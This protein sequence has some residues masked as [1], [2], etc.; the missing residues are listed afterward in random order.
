MRL[1]RFFPDLLW[2][3]SAREECAGWLE[4]FAAFHSLPPGREAAGGSICVAGRPHEFPMPVGP[5]WEETVCPWGHFA[6]N[7]GSS[8]LQVILPE[9]ENGSLVRRIPTFRA[10]LLALTF[11]LPEESLVLHGATLVLHG[12]AILILASSG[13]GK[14]TSAARVPPP[15]SSPGDDWGLLVPD[16]AE[17]YRVHVLP[18]WSKAI[19][20]GG[21]G[22][23]W[24]TQCPYPLRAVCVLKKD[25]ADGLEKMDI[26]RA[27]VCL[28]DAARQVIWPIM[29]IRDPAFKRR[30][31]G[32]SFDAASR[33]ARKIPV[34]LLR[35]RLDGRFW[36]LLEG[37]PDGK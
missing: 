1:L 19:Q 4:E 18:T 29:P 24:D 32:R 36:E 11:L 3:V 14:S 25:T 20:P 30:C 31:L 33:I 15:W 28:N 8:D 9:Q 12:Q 35:A 7:T 13:G 21:G 5:G 2:T 27:A 34:F 23:S 16:G 37:I 22:L 17:G 26:S 10:T 6:W